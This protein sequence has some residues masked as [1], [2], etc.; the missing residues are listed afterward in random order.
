M[1]QEIGALLYLYRDEIEPLFPIEA[2]QFLIAEVAKAINQAEGRNWIPVIVR[3]TGADNFQAIANIFVLAAAQEAGLDKVWCVIADDSEQTEK[4]AQ[5]LSQEI[6]PKINLATASRE[7]IKLAL[8]YLIN[9]SIRPLSGVTLATALDKIDKAP[10]Q[11][12]KE[13]LKEVTT[14]KCGITAA[15]LK[16]FKEV[17]YSTP[18]PPPPKIDLSTATKDKIRLGLE[19]LMNRPVNPLKDINL[20]DTLDKLDNPYRQYWKEQLKEI[21]FLGCGI[22]TAKLKIFKE[23]FYTSPQPLREDEV[24]KDR[25]I[26]NTL[27]ITELKKMAEKRGE[28]DFKKLKKS[29]LIEMLA[30]PS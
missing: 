5:L 3:Q 21:T 6:A 26:L 28:L 13:E 10:R 9:R 11:F 1:K 23:I 2:H 18:A 22:T 24:I 29:E 25:A 16:I 12:W 20:E 15:K 14:L 4:S 19:Y 17:F 7:E 8:D 30:R 27:T